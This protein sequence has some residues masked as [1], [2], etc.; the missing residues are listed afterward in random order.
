LLLVGGIFALLAGS[1]VAA[2]VLFAFAAGAFVLFYG[3]ADRDA[4][5][6]VVRHAASSGHRVR[7][8]AVFL[9]QSFQAWVEAIRA[10]ARLSTQSRSLRRERKRLVLELGDAAY[11]EDDPLVGALR[12]RLREIDEALAARER[13]RSAAVA[14]A[15]GRV[16]EEHVA[17][18][19]TQGFSVND[20]TSGG[21]EEG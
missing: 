9:W 8:W 11:R 19:P 13:E 12:L 6:P 17:A 4:E 20:L 5:S 1:A 2:I 14:K 10:L 16:R 7:G 3:A 21:A 18:Q 15:R